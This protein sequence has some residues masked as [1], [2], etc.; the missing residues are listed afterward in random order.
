MDG[1]RSISS[2]LARLRLE[3]VDKDAGTGS[4]A[5]PS[6]PPPSSL[7][8]LLDRASSASV[9]FHTTIDSI[10]HGLREERDRIA[11]E[12][13]AL[14]AERQQLEEERG[15]VQRVFNDSDVVTLNIGGYRFTTSVCTLRNAPPPS[16]FSAMFSGRHVSDRLLLLLQMS[17]PEGLV[18][19]RSYFIDSFLSPSKALRPD[20]SGALFI[21]RDGRHFPD[22]LNF[23]RDGH[24]NFPALDHNPGDLKYLLELRAEAHYFGLLGLVEQIDRY[25]FA[26]VP[27]V[28]AS[29]INSE[30]SWVYEDGVDQIVLSVDRPCQLVAVGLCASSGSLTCSL[31]VTRVDPANFAQALEAPLEQCA[32][33]FSAGLQAPKES[34]PIV[35]MLLPRPVLLNPEEHYMVQA[36]ITGA[37]SSYSEGCLDM[38]IAGGITVVFHAHESPNGTNEERGQFPA[39]YLRPLDPVTLAPKI[40]PLSADLGDAWALG[41]GRGAV[42]T[43]PSSSTPG[44]GPGSAAGLPST[45]TSTGASP[46]RAAGSGFTPSRSASRDLFTGAGI[47]NFK[48]V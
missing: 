9:S 3:G 14:D 8:S 5:P 28:R 22:I 15:R 43:R 31:T 1:S 11:Q 12:R 24:L 10:V 30:D 39:L 23:L 36:T 20:E 47:S 44:G 7:D 35:R 25:P 48:P 6:A 19:L 32:Q 41:A 37:E 45:P 40:V 34:A 13:A 26:L 27:V 2:S 42:G 29:Q 46:L 18:L 21:D 38:V 33:T 16:L 17:M 4:S